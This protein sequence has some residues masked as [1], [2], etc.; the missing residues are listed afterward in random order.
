M[1]HFSALANS[2]DEK[3]AVISDLEHRDDR[4]PATESE[5]TTFKDIK[6]TH[7]GKATFE[8]RHQKKRTHWGKA[9]EDR[10]QKQ[11]TQRG[12]ATFEERK[13]L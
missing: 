9:I 3:D 11:K 1:G 8:H 6:K 13:S 7:W 2:D 12:K 5:P 10:Y 4:E